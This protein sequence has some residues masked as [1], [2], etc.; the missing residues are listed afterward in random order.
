MNKKEYCDQEIIESEILKSIK[1]LKNGKTPGT[2]GLPPDFY[3]FFWID[4]K[5]VLIKSLEYARSNGELSIEQK[6]GII[7]LI[8]KTI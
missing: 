1:T 2:D 7:T 8:P 5:Y 4:I 3:K 6:R